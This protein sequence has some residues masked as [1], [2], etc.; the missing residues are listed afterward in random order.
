MRSEILQFQ[1]HDEL[2]TWCR[3]FGISL[4]FEPLLFCT[5]FKFSVQLA[6]NLCQ[7]VI[8]ERMFEW[9]VSIFYTYNV[10]KYT[11][12][13]KSMCSYT[14]YTLR[15]RKDSDGFINNFN[16]KSLFLSQLSFVHII[17][18]IMHANQLLPH[19]IIQSNCERDKCD[20]LKK[21]W[22][23]RALVDMFFFFFS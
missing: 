6:L 1:K 21:R 16:F 10:R 5:T 7:R 19:S 17:R 18:L 22:Q 11:Y 3:L 2:S 23:P 9:T 13:Y 20:E 12:I 8:W 14:V 4:H 15:K